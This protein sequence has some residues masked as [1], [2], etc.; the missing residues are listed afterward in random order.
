M[1]K[2][3]I[4]GIHPGQMHTIEITMIFELIFDF[5]QVSLQSLWDVPLADRNHISTSVILF[6]F[7]QLMMMVNNIL[8][9]SLLKQ[10]ADG[11]LEMSSM[12]G[13]PTAGSFSI[14]PIPPTTKYCRAFYT[15]K[16]LFS[17]QTSVSFRQHFSLDSSVPI[18]HQLCKWIGFSYHKI[19]QEKK[20]PMDEFKSQSQK[21]G[22][23][24]PQ[25]QLS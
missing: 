5:I 25:T 10:H 21:A 23:L 15:A 22:T 14:I 9:H 16:Y 2:G 3:N 8:S 12:H 4:C 13:I 11:H 24:L 6:C 17:L 20:L 19:Q 7:L 1:K 18:I